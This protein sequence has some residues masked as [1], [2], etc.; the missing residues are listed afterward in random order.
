MSLRRKKERGPR[1]HELSHKALPMRI[2]YEGGKTR[3]K[4]MVLGQL[5]CRECALGN[6]NGILE[7]DFLWSAVLLELWRDIRS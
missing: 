3:K 4:A 6:W 1:G 2:Q 7:R 5:G